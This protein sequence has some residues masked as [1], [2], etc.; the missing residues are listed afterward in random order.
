MVNVWVPFEVRVWCRRNVPF[1]TTVSP[2]SCEDVEV[3]F[4]LHPSP[5]LLPLN[6]RV[7]F[8]LLLMNEDDRD[9]GKESNQF[10]K[11][12]V[13]FD[14]PVKLFRSELFR[15]TPF[16]GKTKV[17]FEFLFPKLDEGS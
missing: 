3:V 7:P 12:L 8:K 14:S 16:D 11:F 9:L 15:G 1:P 2:K 5:M 17:S 4:G 10:D 6:G 13:V